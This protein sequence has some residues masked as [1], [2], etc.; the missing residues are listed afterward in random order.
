MKA[1]I[2]CLLFSTF[3]W[4]QTDDPKNSIHGTDQPL[5]GR[6]AGDVLFTLAVSGVDG[7]PV[8]LEF[9]GGND[10]FLSNITVPDFGTVDLG[11]GLFSNI[12]AL[13]GRSPIGVTT[14]GVSMFFTDPLGSQVIITDMAGNQ[15]SSFSVLAQVSF[16]E[17]IT[18]HPPSGHLFVVDGSGGNNVYE[19]T[20]T[21]TLVD[22]H[23]VNGSSQDGIAYDSD[24]NSFWL[25]DSGTDTLS[26]YDPTFA[27][28]NSYSGTANAGIGSGEGVAYHSGVVYVMVS[29]E[30]TIV[31]FES[32]FVGVPTLSPVLLGLLTAG[33]LGL[34]LVVRR[35]V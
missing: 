13:N 24:S 27:L 26:Q 2:L 33:L 14:N 28:V 31:A 5:P 9:A 35:R 8:G 15:S 3:L 30:S 4:A 12:A 34:A 32:A 19:Y 18:F 25:Y 23:P 22:T 29:G 11:S 7:L 6:A 16:P 21:G 20:T 1:F 10:L 17:G